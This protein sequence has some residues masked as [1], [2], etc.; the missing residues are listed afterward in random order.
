MGGN[1]RY[2]Y[3]V[4]MSGINSH[5]PQGKYG[6]QQDARQ[7]LAPI[8]VDIPLV[9]P[10]FQASALPTETR[11]ST[12]PQIVSIRAGQ[13]PSDPHDVHFKSSAIS[14]S[15]A[16]QEIIIHPPH[17]TS[18]SIVKS[19]SHTRSQSSETR[20]QSDRLVVMEHARDEPHGGDLPPGQRMSIHESSR[21]V[22]TPVSK[23]HSYTRG[24]PETGAGHPTP[25]YPH[26]RPPSRSAH[27]TSSNNAVPPTVIGPRPLRSASQ[28]PQPEGLTHPPIVAQHVPFIPPVLTQD[29]VPT[30]SAH[31]V[32]GSPPKTGHAH[33]TLSSAQ[34]DPKNAQL[35]GVSRST[36]PSA[37]P[38]VHPTPTIIPQTLSASSR[39]STRDG[40]HPDMVHTLQKSVE[41]Q[42]AT[43]DRPG[44][45]QASN[46]TTIKASWVVQTPATV[47]RARISR[48]EKYLRDHHIN[49][50]TPRAQLRQVLSQDD[51][52]FPRA[53]SSMMKASQ[54]TTPSTISQRN[55]PGTGARDVLFGTPRGTLGSSSP[56]SGAVKEVMFSNSR[57]LSLV[58]S[59]VHAV[60]APTPEHAPRHSLSSYPAEPPQI[61]VVGATPVSMAH[62]LPQGRIDHAFLAPPFPAPTL[63]SRTTSSSQNQQ[64][65]PSQ[66]AVRE[67]PSPSYQPQLAPVHAPSLFQPYRPPSF[68][69]ED[70]GQFSPP[71]LPI[72][73]PKGLED[74]PPPPIETRTTEIIPTRSQTGGHHQMQVHSIPEVQSEMLHIPSQPS[75]PFVM[76]PR[77][78]QAGRSGNDAVPTATSNGFIAAADVDARSPEPAFAHSDDVRIARQEIMGP[79][80]ILPLQSSVLPTKPRPKVTIEDVSEDPSVLNKTIPTSVPTITPLVPSSR[81]QPLQYTNVANANSPFK[82]AVVDQAGHKSSPQSGSKDPFLYRSADPSA[83][84]APPMPPPTAV[85]APTFTHM[86]SSAPPTHPSFVPSTQA[87]PTQRATSHTV[88]SR[89]LQ[90]AAEMLQAS[91]L[92]SSAGTNS[93]VTGSTNKATTA[94]VQATYNPVSTTARQHQ[95]ASGVDVQGPSGFKLASAPT[96]AP[97]PTASVAASMTKVTAQTTSTS[98][99]P[100]GALGLHL[101]APPTSTKSQPPSAPDL[102][103]QQPSR[104]G[105]LSIPSVDP[106]SMTI[107]PTTV[108]KNAYQEPPVVDFTRSRDAASSATRNLGPSS[109]TYPTS[110]RPGASSA[111]TQQTHI[112]TAQPPT[113]HRVVSLPVT[114]SSSAAQKPL[115][116]RKYSQP[117]PSN[118]VSTQP[119][120]SRPPVPEYQSTR[121]P[122]PGHASTPALAR[123]T[124]L[125]PP[126]RTHDFDMLKT[127]S[128]IAPSPM[129]NPDTSNTG[130]QSIAVPVRSRQP[131]T[132]SKDDRKKSSGLFGLFRTRTLSSKAADRPVASTVARASLDQGRVHPDPVPRGASTSATK[133]GNS[134]TP[135]ATSAFTRAEPQFKSKSRAPYPIAN[136][137]PTQVARERG[138]ATSHTFSPFKILTMHSKRN[139][140]V[141]AASLDVCDG[142]TAVSILSSF[143]DVRLIVPVD[144]PTL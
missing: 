96:S 143:F 111:P 37:L 16:P 38:S 27:R 58:L 139:R 12:V 11:A 89:T 100:V 101:S 10:G 94:P 6:G 66:P 57:F 122:A 98:G 28:G 64:P 22:P 75:A 78:T 74:S 54:A 59:S 119:F 23:S 15:D 116:P 31:P 8:N 93:G 49:S 69:S 36:P 127:P 30:S 80:P 129:L 125:S 106:T 138:D 14:H 108:V 136:P 107:M 87:A 26:S 62:N 19:S 126:D 41:R 4:A 46:G 1:Q 141:S 86:P 60:Q 43:D 40:I 90:R 67:T 20:V 39:P 21:A 95:P 70:D 109:H 33:G 71:P 2:G 82:Y 130:L 97:Y 120:P 123:S 63:V 53:S 77:A 113:H 128:S 76:P 72:P 142:N 133:E 131:S 5:Q 45:Q 83:M 44:L 13:G 47:K 115:S 114:P 112:T 110:A 124:R 103:K 34:L 135:P 121:A 18:A 132:D 118:T 88:S 99:T 24:N 91:K 25:P 65:Q 144:R 68:P 92:S 50:E 7:P 52:S 3:R 140:T 85:A 137:P 32:N 73:P 48:E 134:V 17:P 84:L 102:L 29:S 55:S 9:T 61:A 56:R 81:P 35:H 105:T 117:I 51:D 42:P 79:I 104:P